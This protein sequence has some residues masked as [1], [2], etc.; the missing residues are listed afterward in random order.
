VTPMR[1][2]VEAARTA[3]LVLRFDGAE[4]K[5]ARPDSA[6]EL[7]GERWTGRANWPRAAGA[8]SPAP[9]PRTACPDVRD[10]PRTVIRTA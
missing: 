9:S 2:L 7:A 3:G 1:E 6:A 4:L 10:M 5:V 8:G